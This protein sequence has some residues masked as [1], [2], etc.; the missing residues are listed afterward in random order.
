MHH[1]RKF[2]CVQKFAHDYGIGP[3]A[4]H[5]NF[6]CGDFAVF[7]QH[8]QLLAQFRTGRVVYRFHS[9][10]AF[11]GRPVDDLALDTVTTMLY[12]ALFDPNA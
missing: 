7:R 12:R 4:Q 3:I 8:F 1:V 6:Y 9:L 11:L 5:P 2:V 10:R